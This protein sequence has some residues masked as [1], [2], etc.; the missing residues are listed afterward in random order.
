M[1]P[2]HLSILFL[3]LSYLTSW[4]Q[5]FTPGTSYFDNTGYVEYIPGNTP[6][7]ISVPHGGYLEPE[8]IPDRDCEAYTCTR[9]AYTQEL[10]RSI[11]ASYFEETGCYPHIIIN[12][13]HRKKFDANRDIDEAAG[14]NATV[15]Q[16][17][18]AYHAFI[19]SAKMKVE[20]QYGRG[21][22]LDIHGHGHEV[23]RLELGY[24]IFSNELQMADDNLNNPSLVEKSS[25]RKLVE[26]NLQSLSHAELLRGSQSF[27]TLFDDALVPSVP[28]TADP[29]PGENES[30]FSGGYNTG[31]HGSSDGGNI[32]AIQIECHQDIRFDEDI[33]AAFADTLVL[34]VNDYLNYHYNDDYNDNYCNIITSINDDFHKEDIHIYPNPATN[35]LF[36]ESNLQEF[37]ISIYNGIGQ[38]VL[39]TEW[40]GQAIILDTLKD[41]YYFI[42][43]HQDHIPI[44]TLKLIKQ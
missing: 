22:F 16:A 3:F 37:Q 2:T 17:W 19:D 42:R 5:E 44:K 39:A 1:K 8:S 27:G 11:G 15:E 12:L 36:I 35:Q 25:I 28:S 6:L 23:Q 21:L 29:Y 32:D 38:E 20:T 30:Y 43:F 33:R 4:G 31:R 9:D 18:Y 26:D 10:G 14:G 41:G 13:L 24:R 7:V 40:N 34:V